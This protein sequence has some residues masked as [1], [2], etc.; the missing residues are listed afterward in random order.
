MVCLGFLNMF[1]FPHPAVWDFWICHSDQAAVEPANSWHINCVFTHQFSVIFPESQSTARGICVCPRP[2]TSEYAALATHALPSS[3]SHLP[4]M[5]GH[6]TCS[7]R[8]RGL[9]PVPPKAIKHTLLVKLVRLHTPV[10][11]RNTAALIWAPTTCT[12]PSPLRC[13]PP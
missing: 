9:G 6:Q 12:Q 7:A 13:L 3:Y 10:P 8:T 4:W 11:G 2:N 1:F 5:M